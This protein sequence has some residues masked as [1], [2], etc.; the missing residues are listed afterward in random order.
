MTEI[1][2]IY[3]ALSAPFPQEALSTDV[4][5]GFDLTS[6]KAQY[7]KERL[8]EVL[9]IFGWRIFGE[10]KETEK[11]VLYFGRL[12]VIISCNEIEL[13]REVEAVGYSD[14]KRVAADAYKGAQTDA[15]SKCASFVGVGNDVFKGKVKPP[16]KSNYT[17]QT[18]TSSGVCSDPANYICQ[19]GKFKGEMIQAIN[20]KELKDY[21]VYITQLGGLEGNMKEFIDN[22]R[23]FLKGGK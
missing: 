5:R 18:K 17:Q 12:E 2:E 8:S 21:C 1:K 3:K 6:I 19:I 23:A 14:F 16:S 10:Y 20:R 7:I 13:K 11:G 22:A 4:S 15:L 9:G